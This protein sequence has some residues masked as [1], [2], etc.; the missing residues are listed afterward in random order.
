M[1]KSSIL[2]RLYRFDK[3]D[4][5]KDSENIHAVE[6]CINIRRHHRLL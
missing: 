4:Y 6:M 1:K 5:Q 3:G 2:M